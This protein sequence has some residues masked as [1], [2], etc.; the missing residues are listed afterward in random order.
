MNSE[1]F[2]RPRAPEGAH[3]AVHGVRD[4]GRRERLPALLEVDDLRAQDA[5]RL[6][7]GLGNILVVLRFLLRTFNSSTATRQIINSASTLLEA[8]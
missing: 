7:D 8:S 6:A 2:Q 5:A 1:Y 3:V 4:E